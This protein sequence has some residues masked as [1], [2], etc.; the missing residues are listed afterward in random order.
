MFSILFNH[1]IRLAYRKKYSII[2]FINFE[3]KF[4]EYYIVGIRFIAKFSDMCFLI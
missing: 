2:D 4:S 1:L 3:D